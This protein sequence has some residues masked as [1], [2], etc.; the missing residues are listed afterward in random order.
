MRTLTKWA[1]RAV[2]AFKKKIIFFH[3]SKLMIF[4]MFFFIKIIFL[5]I[6]ILIALVFFILFRKPFL[7]DDYFLVILY[8]FNY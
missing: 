2:L 6:F 3:F 7:N 4:Y 8:A 5:F 1:K